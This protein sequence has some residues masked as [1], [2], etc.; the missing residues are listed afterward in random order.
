MNEVTLPPTPNWYLSNIC[1]CSFDGT[2]AWGAR[3]VIIIAK[4]NAGEKT[5]Q[6]SIIKNAYK[7]R[8]TCVAFTPPFEEV[9]PHLLASTADENVIKV[10]DAQ[11]LSTVYTYTLEAGKHAIGIDWSRKEYALYA[12]I[13]DGSILLWN[14]HFDTVITIS[15]GKVSPTC[16]SAC[17]HDPHLVAVGSKSGLVFILNFQGKGKIV[18]KLR[19]HDIDIVNLSWCP[20]ETNVFN[21]NL[22]KDSLLAS[23][24]KDRSI[25]IW[26]AGGDGRYEMVIPL[27]VAPLDSQQHRS[28][29]NASVGNWIVVDWIEPKLLLASSFWGEL[30]AWD[31]STITKGKPAVKLIHAYHNRGLF[32]IAHVPNAQD[33]SVQNWRLRERHVIWTVAQD[34]RVICCGIKETNVEIVYDIFTQT[35]FVYCIAACPLDTSRVAF[36]VGDAMLRLWNLS[37]DHSTS[38]DITMLWQKIKGKIRTISW[39]P[40]KE[41]LLAY[42]TEEG[43]VGVFNTNSNKLPVLYRQYHRGIVYTIHWGPSPESGEYVLYS[44]GEGELV[45]YEKPSQEPKSLLKKDCTEFSWKPD[46]SCLAVGFEDG[47]I[48]FF[49]RKFEIQGYAKIASRMIY[50]LVWHPESTATDLTLSPLRNYL[51]VSSKSSPAIILDLTDFIDHLTKVEDSSDGSEENRE[52]YKVNQVVTTLARES[53]RSSVC[54]AWSPYISG[55]LVSGSYDWTAQVWNVQTEELIAIYTG[56]IGPVVC[57]MWSPLNPDFIITGSADSTLRIWKIADNAPNNELPKNTTKKK[58]I[59]A[60]NKIADTT[61]V[62]NDLTELTDGVSECSISNVSPIVQKKPVTKDVKNKKSERPSYFTKNIKA[63]NDK[64]VFLNPLLNVVKSMK[65]E[66]FDAEKI[67]KDT[68]CDTMSVLFL[69]DENLMSFLTQERTTHAAKN[70]HNLVTEM[71]LWCDNLKLNLDEAVKEKRL[72]DFLVSL[73]ASLSVKTWKDMCQQYAYQLIAEGNPCKAVSYLLCI[74]KTYEAIE[75][76]QDANLY[77]EAY[78]LARSKLESDDPVLTD[79]LKNWATYSVNSGDFEQAALV[80]A[81]L[82]ELSDVVKY[83]ARRKDATMLITAAEIAVLCDDNTLGES[84]AEQAMIMTLKSENHELAR[85]IIIKFPRFKYYEVYFLAIEELCKTM[86]RT[87]TPDMVLTWLNGKSEYDLLGTLE[88]RCGECNSYYEYLYENRSHY[89]AINEEKKLGLVLCNDLAL[90]VASKNEKERLKHILKTLH[91][92]TEFEKGCTHTFGNVGEKLNLSMEFI[93]KLSPKSLMDETGIYKKNDYSVS[94]SLRAY[95]CYI[96]LNWLLYN[97]DDDA[98]I[99]NLQ[100]YVSVIED[101]LE[102]TINKETIEYCMITNNVQAKEK[103]VASA[104][105]KI[106]EEKGTDENVESLMEDL[107]ALKARKEEITKK[108]VCVPHPM[109]VYGQ[110]NELCSKIPDEILRNK[111]AESLSNTWKKATT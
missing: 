10:W 72:N 69:T 55:Y 98:V 59:K 70:N 6:Y 62:Q 30:I 41:N 100:T 110:L 36:G 104:I 111:F 27:P 107:N 82:G 13:S 18:Y 99:D 19:G 61:A 81:K 80:Y 53:G 48:S 54:L 4:P 49:N 95:L 50:S 78:V 14:M 68:S 28:K 21:E 26:R 43:R 84:L 24:G 35:G 66:S 108:L 91:T 15:L 56:H 86:D 90:V 71:D 3:N 25:Y 33:S 77:K 60:K 94:V 20:S 97:I 103:T 73:S 92:I 1:A 58:Q 2:V 37:A 32:C 64:T 40:E 12:A 63:V 11:T 93:I 76:F 16:I 22:N 38:F 45:Y 109:M 57:C 23:A 34:R 79:I 42:A 101:L 106:Q 39:H 29:L 9:N 17:P 51:A 85:N 47:T 46:F 96:L 105:C 67:Q 102:D 89:T 75:V 65:D 87:I 52:P 44:C 83:L 7:Q 88:T 74:H 8:V 5:L 31:L